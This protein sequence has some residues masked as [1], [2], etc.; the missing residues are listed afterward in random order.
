MKF[1]WLLTGI[2]IALTG[3]TELAAENSP[4]SSTTALPAPPPPGSIITPQSLAAPSPGNLVASQ[5]LQ[6]SASGIGSAKLGMTIG[7]LKQQLGTNTEFIVGWYSSEE[8]DAVAVIQGGIVQYYIPY[9][10]RKPL[11]DSDIIVMLSTENSQYRTDKNVG[12]GTSIKKA[13]EVYGDATLHHTLRVEG[14]EYVRFANA[15]AYL[16]F[17][18]GS[19]VGKGENRLAGVYPRLDP[20]NVRNLTAYRQTKEYRE[21][22]TI[23]AVSVACPRGDCSKL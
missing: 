3:S 15:P 16:N 12:P 21:N 22:A 9:S 23:R 10:T 6:I 2:F 20:R 14:I 18:L 19:V 17:R 7:E 11:Q 1:H 13:E 4:A 5:N 8:Y